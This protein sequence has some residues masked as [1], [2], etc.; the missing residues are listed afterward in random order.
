MRDERQKH[1]SETDSDTDKL[2]G[3]MNREPPQINVCLCQQKWEGIRKGNS[4]SQGNC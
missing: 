1:G 4:P 2:S 3:V